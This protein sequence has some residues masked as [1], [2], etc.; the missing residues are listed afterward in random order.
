MKHMGK[1]QTR[2]LCG[3]CGQ[4][5]EEYPIS[6]HQ[7][8]EEPPTVMCVEPLPANFN[9]LKSNVE[10]EPW[11]SSGIQIKQLAVVLSSANLP[12]AEFPGDA[13]YGEEGAG[14]FNLKAGRYKKMIPINTS[15]VDQL[16]FGP[17]NPNGVIPTVISV[18]AEGLDALVLLGAA[19]SL[20]SGGV[21][22]VEFEY[23]H[24]HP[25]DIIQLE[26][27]VGYLD[28][29]QYDCFFAGNNGKSY[30]V[31]GCWE[32]RFEFH[33]MSNLVC[34]SR[35]VRTPHTCWHDALEAASMD[36]TDGA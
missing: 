25:W 24:K 11:A 20:A 6:E 27:I 14:V 17:E 33:V 28:N 15:T 35:L 34:A 3:V 36:S 21:A 18:D 16:T 1:K 31:T 2:N 7:L 30:K 23:H 26:W 22:Y 9:M 10:A 29:L 32:P 5:R 19:R 4:C 8:S 13:A 12:M